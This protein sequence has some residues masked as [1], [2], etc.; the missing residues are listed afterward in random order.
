MRTGG[1]GR[2]EEKKDVG[3]KKKGGDAE[4]NKKTSFTNCLARL[5]HGSPLEAIELF[6]GPPLAD[7]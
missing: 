7:V 5:A 6:R 2:K 4:T 3:G 1:K